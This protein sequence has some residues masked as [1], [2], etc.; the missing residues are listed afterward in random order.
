QKSDTDIA[1]NAINDLI[2]ASEFKALCK[3]IITIAPQIKENKNFDT[4]L[5]RSYLF[6]INS[7]YGLTTTLNALAKLIDSCGLATFAKRRL[8]IETNVENALDKLDLLDVDEYRIFAIDISDKM[9]S[10]NDPAFKKLLNV[11]ACNYDKAIF[12]FVIP[13]VDKEVLKNTCHALNDVMFV[14]E[15]SFS[16]LTKKEMETFAIKEI[17]KRNFTISKN[18]LDS[19]HARIAEEKSDGRFYGLKTITKVVNEL[20]YTKQLTNA[21]SK[22][23]NRVISKK[24]ANSI[25]HSDL[26]DLTGYQL[27]EKLVASDKLKEKIDEIVSQIMLAKQD[28][29]L[30]APCIHMQFVGNPGTGKTTVARIIGKILKEKGVL[31]VG[32]FHEYAGRD[33]CGKYIGETAPKTASICRDAYGSVLFIDE[34]YSLYRTE[35]AGRDYGREALDTII[36]EMENHRTDL[37]VILAGYSDEMG[38]LMKGNS[39]LS[40]RIPYKIEFPNFT[41]DQLAEIFENM[42]KG[43]FKFS[44]DLLVASKKYFAELS[45][46]FITSKEFSNARFVRNLFERTWAKASM[47]CQLAGLTSVTLT[48][49]DFEIA[50]MDDEFKKTEPKRRKIGFN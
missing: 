42:V 7:G 1:M 49:A 19:F 38:L 16:P 26:N 2:G 3:E 10:L 31:R 8:V 11:L 29:S 12:V 21:L 25:C 13:F 23:P 4:F 14:K 37:V 27:L 36:A 24:D 20:I 5:S 46:D 6:S 30:K 45:E 33:L 35:D 28:K 15:V 32:S 9:S 48:G 34:A 18:A 47:R 17:E 43:S 40:S 44:D 22:K 39:G 41:R 50:I